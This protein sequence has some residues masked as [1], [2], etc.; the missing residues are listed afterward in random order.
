MLDDVR[1]WQLRF[2]IFG[3]IVY[4]YD[5]IVYYRTIIMLNNSAE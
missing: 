5:V 1:S 3:M 4:T 2:V